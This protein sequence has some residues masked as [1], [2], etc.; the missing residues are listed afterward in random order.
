MKNARLGL[1]AVAV[2]LGTMGTPAWRT[3]TRAL[4]GAS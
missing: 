2:A 4:R 1:A 3:T